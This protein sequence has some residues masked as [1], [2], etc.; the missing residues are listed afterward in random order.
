MSDP[1]LDPVLDLS[2]ATLL[3]ACKGRVALLPS[4]V[5]HDDDAWP[6]FAKVR[7]AK[8]KLHMRRSTFLRVVV[9]QIP[10]RPGLWI[11]ADAQEFFIDL[12]PHQLQGASDQASPI[13]A[14]HETARIVAKADAAGRLPDEADYG[15]TVVERPALRDEQREDLERVAR[16]PEKRG[17]SSAVFSRDLDTER[18]VAMGN[19]T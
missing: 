2:P 7:P 3:R 10:V 4:F 5:V 19:D 9:P 12:K 16:D 18:D 1:N 8:G 14:N 15:T 17:V 13:E 11:R 6:W